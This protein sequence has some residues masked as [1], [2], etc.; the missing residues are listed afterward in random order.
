ML[1]HKL[2]F[3]CTL[4]ICGHARIGSSII[5]QRGPSSRG[6]ATNSRFQL[7]SSSEYRR[8]LFLGLSCSV[9]SLYIEPVANVITYFFVNHMIISSMRM[10]HNSIS[11]SKI[12]T[13]QL[14]VETVYNW[15]G[16]NSLALNLDKTEVI[17]V[18][19]RARLQHKAPL[20]LSGLP[21]LISRSLKREESRGYYQ[22]LTEFQY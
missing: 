21:E 12:T 22:K 20:L 10:T 7:P 11:W 4:I 19:T 15:F 2:G 18:S 8:V 9:C 14:C 5:W 17:I 6:L 1:L 13:H 16:Q 3:T